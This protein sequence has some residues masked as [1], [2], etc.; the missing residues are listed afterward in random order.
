MK[1]LFLVRGLEYGGAERQL[2]T[3]ALGLK[4]RGVDVRVL[5][6][7]GGGPLEAELHQAGVPLL[8]LRKRGRWDIVGCLVRLALIVR[9]ERPD[10]LYGFMPVQN[11]LAGFV[12]PVRPSMR[13]VWGMRASSFDLTGYDWLSRWSYLMV[14]RFSAVPDLV[15]VNSQSGLS[16]LA[17]QNFP[18]SKTQLVANG[19][20]CTGFRPDPRGRQRI[21][22]DWRV[23]DDERLIG[24]V[25]RFDPL[26]DHGTFLQAAALLVAERPSVRFVC[27]GDGPS[28]LAVKLRSLADGL[29]LQKHLIW[30]GT[31][32]DMRAVY[33]S[34]DVLGLC[35]ISEGF[36]NVIG[37]A[38]ACAVPCVVTDVGDSAIVVGDTGVVVPVSDPGA[39][40]DGWQRLLALS[41]DQRDKL[42]ARARLR[43][44]DRFSVDALCQNVNQALAGLFAG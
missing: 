30:A 28:A 29:G 13:V 3:L 42:G 34:L 8:G 5:V 35:S 6:L 21:R 23:R 14:R 32:D 7:Y 9:R 33:S 25:A 36:P 15:I 12:R 31:R 10:V 38:M 43:I 44:Q 26:K 22:G 17:A 20:D 1:I 18:P 11:L 2:A 16:D 41:D 19:I 4:A 27:V 39:L 40:A 24:L 37:E